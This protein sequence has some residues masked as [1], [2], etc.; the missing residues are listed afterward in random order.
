MC[1][2]ERFG[3]L[4]AKWVFLL[5][6][7]I[8]SNTLAIWCKELTQDPNGGKDWRQKEKAVAE[9]ETVRR[10]HW[11]NGHEFEPTPGDSAEQGWGAAQQVAESRTWLSDRTT[12]TTRRRQSREPDGRIWSLQSRREEKKLPPGKLGVE[13]RVSVMSCLRAWTP[14]TRRDDLQPKSWGKNQ[15]P[16]T[17]CG[18]M[19]SGGE[20][21]S[22]VEV[23]MS[24]TSWEFFPVLGLLHFLNLSR[25]QNSPRHI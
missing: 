6:N 7:T 21:L 2:G 11:L 14:I 16:Q 19:G 9:D 1:N 22:L 15:V 10:H 5:L 25:H 13:G 24:R 12:T 4:L 3:R 17:P 23:G 20:T 18:R 8:R